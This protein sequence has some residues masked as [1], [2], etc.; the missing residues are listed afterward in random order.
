M[1]PQFAAAMIALL[2]A[3]PPFLVGA[4]KAAPD[5]RKA[6]WEFS[7]LRPLGERQA[8]AGFQI[9]GP[10]PLL[11]VTLPSKE[12]D[13]KPIPISR[14]KVTVLDSKGKPLTVAKHYEHGT[15]LFGRDNHM[16]FFQVG[17]FVQNIQPEE[18]SLVTIVG[19]GGKL[20]IRFANGNAQKEQIPE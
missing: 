1:S 16:A 6:K 5:D 20:T 11:F 19:F 13:K 4:D 2:L 3:N 9:L 12:E 10:R 17:T 15:L 7:E 18:V 14:L 8:S